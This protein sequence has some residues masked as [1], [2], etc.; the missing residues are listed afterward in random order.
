MSEPPTPATKAAVPPDDEE[1]VVG[2]GIDFFDPNSPL[3]AYY[4]RPITVGLV[5]FLVVILFVSCAF[6]LWHTDVWGHVRYGQW[7]VEN[8]AI[9]DG[10]PFCPWWDGRQR[11]TQFYTLTQLAM[12]GAYAT[13]ET[14]AGGDEMNR[15]AGGVEMLRGLHGLLTTARF[16][17]LMLVFHRISRSWT[18]ALVGAV[19]VA[20]LDLSNLAVLRPQT[21]AQLFFAILLLPL[22]RSLLSRRAMLLIPALAVVWAN[23]HGSYV[24][25][26][27]LLALLL[28]GRVAER[29]MSAPDWMRAVVHD[30]HARRLAV[31]LIGSVVAIGLLNP[32]GFA[33]YT[34]TIEMSKHPSLVSA[35]GEWQPL[36]FE[37]GTG[38]HW[39][40]MLSL[41]VIGTTQLVSRDA[42]SPG[43][44]LAVFA[45]GVGVSLQNRFVIW[46][47]MVVPW[48]L[49][50]QWAE[51]GERWAG[52]RLSRWRP[53]FLCTCLAAFVGVAGLQYV[54]P[55]QWLVWGHGVT[56]EKGMSDGTPWQVTRQVRGV[57][58]E[59]EKVPGFDA[60]LAANYP[61]GKF[62]GS[63]LATP[64]QGDYLMWA[65]APEVPVTY[66][67]IHLFPPDFWEELGV[68]GQGSPGWGDVLEK[69]RVNLLV[70]EAEFAQ[71][72]RAELVKSP[73]WKILVDETGLVSKKPEKLN[74]QLIAIRV[75][76]L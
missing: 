43:R 75:R 11:F 69:Y 59:G 58:A 44:L 2:A 71:H 40:F 31:A 7:M 10:E 68:V 35:V 24:V 3:A 30:L 6:P 72:L 66:A 1:I 14:I 28:A 25:A 32:Y 56:A 76:P 22:S 49:L 17:V 19:A 55:V 29:V 50:P 16:A 13:G 37:W 53:N 74:R 15:L 20:F 61:G 4:T 8:R 23:G 9:P 34:R 26:L 52:G 12:Y 27:V 67:H 38:W 73:A 46:W 45:F 47:A 33:L 18:L 65:L 64:M 70:V 57:A 54:G 42:M 51:I 21:F 48:V 63:I 41:L 60:V 39:V 36:G 5:A 62:R